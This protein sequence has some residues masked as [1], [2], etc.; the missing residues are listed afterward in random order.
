MWLIKFIRS[1]YLSLLKYLQ[2]GHI[3]LHYNLEW[4]S[5]ETHSSEMWCGWQAL[6]DSQ[7]ITTWNIL[8]KTWWKQIQSQRWLDLTKLNSCNTGTWYG[9][10][11]LKYSV[12]I[13]DSVYKPYWIG[14]NLYKCFESLISFL[15]SFTF[16]LRCVDSSLKKCHKLFAP[17]LRTT[18]H[19]DILTVAEPWFERLSPI[20]IF[21]AQLF[22][23][24]QIIS[25]FSSAIPWNLLPV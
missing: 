19:S 17:W 7:V 24:N 4:K 12:I 10:I 18:F 13:E 16:C 6:Y 2:I 25:Q 15:C 14:C 5:L 22:W 23:L 20:T 8:L 11:S 1:D 21:C 9:C 3:K